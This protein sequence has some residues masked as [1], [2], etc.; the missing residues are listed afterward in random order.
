MQGYEPASSGNYVNE[1]WKVPARALRRGS[2]ELVWEYVR[3]STTH[4]WLHSLR[5][6]CPEPEKRGKRKSNGKSDV[7]EAHLALQTVTE[8]S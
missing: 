7:H 5:L 3:G 8:K 2:N 1:V 4:Y 6:F